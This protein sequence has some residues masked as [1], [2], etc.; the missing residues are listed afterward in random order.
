[1]TRELL[2]LAAPV[3]ADAEADASGNLSADSSATGGTKFLVPILNL[4]PYSSP[5]F[6]GARA[7]VSGGGDVTEGVYEVTVTFT[8]A[9][10]DTDESATGSGVSQGRAVVTA[11]DGLQS[12]G[13]VVFAT[14][15]A[16]LPNN[17]GTLV[18]Q[19]VVTIAEAGS[20]G[21]SA[22][23]QSNSSANG[24]G[25]S[26]TTESSAQAEISFARVG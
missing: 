20:L 1:M 2:A 16:E 23:I 12:D 14:K 17:T 9:D 4:F 21:I 6:G 10:T 3:S 11:Y 7:V 18:V 22:E 26:A 5:T 15:A 25:N 19:F 8:D 13:Q 24:T